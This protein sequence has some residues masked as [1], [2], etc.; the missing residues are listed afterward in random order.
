LC[1]KNPT[2][3]DQGSSPDLGGGRP[4]NNRPSH[5]TAK[6]KF[7]IILPPTTRSSKLHF[8]SDFSY[9]HPRRAYEYRFCHS[10]YMSHHIILTVASS[11]E[12]L[13][14]QSPML[15]T[16]TTHRVPAPRT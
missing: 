4:A 3:T 13:I 6:T 14:V 16:R 8:F 1:T 12:V 2:Q 9:T 7:N 15:P 11:D 10:C 5:G